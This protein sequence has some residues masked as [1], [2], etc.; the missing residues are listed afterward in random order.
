MYKRLLA[1]FLLLCAISP[2]AAHAWTLKTWVKSQGGIISSSNGVAQTSLDGSV[3]RNYTTT[4]TETVIVD[5]ADGWKISSLELDGFIQTLSDPT[6]TQSLSYPRTGTIRVFATFAR[7]SLAL[8]A[9]AGPNGSVNKSIYPIVYIGAQ[10]PAK[11]FTFTPNSGYAVSAINASAG[12]LNTDFQFVNAVTGLPTSLGKVGEKVKVNVFN[13][14]GPITFTATFAGT[15]STPDTTPT[16]ET[17]AQLGRTQCA[18]C[19]ETQGVSVGIYANWSSSMHKNNVVMCY[20]CH[21]GTNTGGHPGTIN[22]WSV[23]PKTFDY[24][25]SGANFCSTCH[26]PAIVTDFE[27]SGHVVPAG[28]AS[29]SFCHANAHNVNAA[30]VNC[31]TPDNPYGLPWPPTGLEFHD[32]YTG[33]DLCTACH[34][35]HNPG[36]VSGMSDAAHY[37]NITS[38]KYP[39]SYVTSEGR[40]V[41]TVMSAIL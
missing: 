17:A 33:T 40:T 8:R 35:L 20:N 31:H 2:A 29:C 39:A 36:I 41:P 1:L 28:S 9:S 10:S 21:V 19:H 26:S 13:I 27:A 16:T 11:T 18:N 12:T 22:S 24:T 5:P 30:C 32:A 7:Q 38:G 6:T 15:P 25:A 3:T 34:N 23:N 37:N 4:G 14:P